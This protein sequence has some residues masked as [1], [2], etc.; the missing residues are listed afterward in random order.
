MTNADQPN[1]TRLLYLAAAAI[2]I[3]VGLASRKVEGLFPSFLGK[4]PGDALWALMAFFLIGALRPAL[5]IC[6]TAVFA[7]AVC[8][9]VE[10]GQLYQAPWIRAVRANPLGHLVLGS[11]FHSPDLVA[12]AV[13]VASGAIVVSLFSRRAPTSTD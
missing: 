4:Y 8:F 7:L 9:A 12:Y 2:V 5:S 13:G 10:F 6:R 11:R 3:A 1:R